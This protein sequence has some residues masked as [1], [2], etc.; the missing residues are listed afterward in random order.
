MGTAVT[1]AWLPACLIVIALENPTRS[2]TLESGV[3]NEIDSPGRN[4]FHIVDQT[5]PRAQE[6]DVQLVSLRPA[7]VHGVSRLHG[8]P[9]ALGRF[10]AVSPIRRQAA[11]RPR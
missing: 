4:D 10:I 9:R 2:P 8:H 1:F 6:S 11:I 7:V 5:F 3:S